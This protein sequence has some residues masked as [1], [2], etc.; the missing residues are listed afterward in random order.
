MPTP[1]RPLPAD[2]IERSGEMNANDLAKHYR[3]GPSIISRWRRETGLGGTHKGGVPARPMPEDF[4]QHAG[5]TLNADLII[6]YQASES[7]VVR[8]RKECGI[9]SPPNNRGRPPKQA[10]RPIPDNF[11]KVAPH[12]SNIELAAMYSAGKNTVAKWRIQ[13]GAPHIR[14]VKEP[15]PK[16]QSGPRARK[17]PTGFLMKMG[18]PKPAVGYV[19]PADT[20]IEGSAAQVLRAYAPTYRCDR[21]GRQECPDIAKTYW[22]FGNVVLSPQEMMERAQAKGWTCA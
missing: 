3:C 4:A 14:P 22:R 1:M 12:M 9:P 7:Q 5:G 17:L 16:V 2:F 11:A 8:W 20:S 13:I 6:K 18:K 15:K 19:P 10:C 21:R